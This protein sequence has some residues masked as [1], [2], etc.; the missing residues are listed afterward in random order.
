MHVTATSV[1]SPYFHQPINIWQTPSLI[2][3]HRTDL[4]YSKIIIPL[5][6]NYRWS[7][8]HHVPAPVQHAKA[9]LFTEQE[10]RRSPDPVTMVSRK[11]KSV[12]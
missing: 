6:L 4:Q 1:H 2:C 12:T 9:P 3:E 11:Q 10:A 7:G 5:I 8:K